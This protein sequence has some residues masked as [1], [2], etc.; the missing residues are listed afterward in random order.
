MNKAI[1]ITFALCLIMHLSLFGQRIIEGKVVNSKTN[2][3]LIGAAVFIPKSNK[4]TV[5]DL[6][7][8]F[9]LKIDESVTQLTISYLG[10]KEYTLFLDQ[11]SFYNVRLLVGKKLKEVILI[12]KRP[13]PLRDLFPLER[14][15]EAGLNLGSG[16]QIQNALNRIPGVYMHSGALN[17]NR[18]TIRGIG[19]RSPFATAKIRAYLDEIPL[20]SGIGETTIEDLDLS[21][22]DHVEVWKGPAPSAYGAGL[23]GMIHLFSPRH[24]YY[25]EN[26]LK[27]DFTVGS[28][29]MWRTSNTVE[30]YNKPFDLRINFNKLHSDGYRENNRYDRDNFN[31]ISKVKYENQ[32]IS[33]LLNYTNLKAFIPSSINREDYLNEPQKAAF[34]WGKVKGN[35]D[36]E[37]ILIGVSNEFYKIYEKFTIENKSSIFTGSYNN[38]EV[39]PFNIL[40]EDNELIGGRTK[41]SLMSGKLSKIDIGAE[42]FFEQ[43]DWQTFESNDGALGA[44]LS[45]NEESRV[46]YNLFIESKNIKLAQGLTASLGLNY[47]NTSYELLDRYVL[48]S[49]DISGEYKYDP[50]LSPRIGLLYLFKNKYGF[51]ANVAQGFSTP[52][53]EETLTAEG[54]R[55]PDIRQETGWNF[56]LGT[57]GKLSLA[58]GRFSYKLTTFRM[59]VKDLLV[60]ERN[61]LD[62]YIG[63]NAG[64]TLHQGVEFDSGYERGLSKFWIGVHANYTFSDYSFT[65]FID[66]QNDYSGNPLTGTPPHNLNFGFN[67]DYD[68]KISLN[69]SYQFLDA[70][71]MRDDNSIDSDAYQLANLKLSYKENIG[72]KVKLE[73]SGGINNLFD[74]KYASMILINASSFNGSAPRYYYPG[75]PRNY[76]GR[77]ALSYVF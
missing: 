48:D 9:S 70:F 74:E 22:I 75:M 34:T 37:K 73:L 77:V 4:G 24:K 33:F 51:F 10:F 3:A 27:T 11:K 20:T 58:K 1:Q 35:E 56:E 67:V 25:D 55:N 53:L 42:V 52:T 63:R 5:T 41:F 18:I 40:K 14:I 8:K 31:I 64:K 65:E 68:R 26:N 46:Y 38:F 54:A 12:G 36:N 21:I 30:I 69:F 19:N 43:Y 72:R 47:N 13:D 60:A 16:I 62:Q 45:D 23:G 66:D 49:I 39:R 61:A 17:T 44:G 71:P 6:N 50:V 29:G 2:E 7:G 32:T 76:F 28:Y 15:L 59:Y 57:K